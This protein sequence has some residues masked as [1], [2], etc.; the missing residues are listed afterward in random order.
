MGGKPLQLDIAADNLRDCS[1][2]TVICQDHPGLFARLSG[3]CALAGLSILDA[4][5]TT[6]NDGLAIDTLHV[7]CPEAGTRAARWYAGRPGAPAP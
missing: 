5:I 3:A 6:T 2:I 7:K 4:R 1:E